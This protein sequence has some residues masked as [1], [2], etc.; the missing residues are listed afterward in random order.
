MNPIFWIEFQKVFQQIKDDSRVRVVVLSSAARIFS[1][2]LSGEKK[3][4]KEREK[5]S[6][7]E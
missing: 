2:G 3:R 7:R 5:E 4:K 1:S 6:G